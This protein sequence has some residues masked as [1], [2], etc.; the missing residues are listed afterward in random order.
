IVTGTTTTFNAGVVKYRGEVYYL[1]YG[2]E[3]ASQ[4]DNLGGEIELGLEATH[5]SLLT[6][7]VTGDV[8]TRTDNTTQ[9]PDWVTRFDARYVNEPFRVSY[10]LLYLDD[11]LRIPD[12][13]VE[14]DPHPFVSSN[15]THNISAQYRW[16]EALTVRAGIDNVT[17][18]EPSYPTYHYGDVIGRQYFLGAT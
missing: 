11:V 17:N 5:T 12:S 1:N 16:N 9:Q 7:S 18:E 4:F 15:V 6:S 8:F 10:Q 2:F 13:T 14:N 3:L